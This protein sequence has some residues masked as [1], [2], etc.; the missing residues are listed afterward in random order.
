MYVFFIVFGAVSV[1]TPFERNTVI[2]LLELAG[3]KK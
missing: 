2:V 3:N 1:L